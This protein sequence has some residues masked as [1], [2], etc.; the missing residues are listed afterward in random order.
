MRDYHDWWTGQS[1][2]NSKRNPSTHLTAHKHLIGLLA[3][4]DDGLRHCAAES[5]VRHDS[6]H[7][8]ATVGG[9]G[10]GGATTMPVAIACEL[11]RAAMSR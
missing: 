4:P 6:H 10:D 8:S 1:P 2:F 3:T 9:D 5:A 11:A 7:A